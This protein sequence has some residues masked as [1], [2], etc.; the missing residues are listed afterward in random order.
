MFIPLDQRSSCSRRSRVFTMLRASTCDPR[1]GKESVHARPSWVKDHRVFALREVLAGVGQAAR[2]AGATGPRLI[3][4]SA[5]ASVYCA[6]ARQVCASCRPTPQGMWLQ[7]NA[8][9]RDGECYPFRAHARGRST[10]SR[11]AGR[12]RPE[13]GSPRDSSALWNN[14]GAREIAVC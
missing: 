10:P 4:S 9:L 14:Q 7:N 3:V 5:S 2:I 12:T 6:S 11:R 8:R 1:D 13:L